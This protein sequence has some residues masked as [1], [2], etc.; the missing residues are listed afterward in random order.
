MPRRR[1]PSGTLLPR[2]PE[3]CPH[4]TAYLMNAGWPSDAG[5]ASAAA[6]W[7]RDQGIHCERDFVG[8]EDIQFLPNAESLPL[9]AIEFLQ[10]LVLPISFLPVVEPL[11]HVG[12]VEAARY[13]YLIL[14]CLALLCHARQ[15]LLWEQRNRNLPGS[16]SVLGYQLGGTFGSFETAQRCC[17]QHWR[18]GMDE[19]GTGSSSPRELPQVKSQ[20][21][22][23]CHA[24]VQVHGNC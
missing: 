6:L 5:P 21:A 20:H 14:S 24:L 12:P 11:R 22:L 19:E 3:P 16:G 2:P 23:W 1:W 7:L 17:R 10:S 15:A 9:E 13:A 4:M 8:M 18:R